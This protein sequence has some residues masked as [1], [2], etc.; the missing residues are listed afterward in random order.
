MA[1][2]GAFFGIIAQ[3][4]LNTVSNSG[5]LVTGGS[6]GVSAGALAYVVRQIASGKLVHR[7]VARAEEENRA[8]ARSAQEQNRVYAGFIEKRLSGSAYD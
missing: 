4:D 7:D 2:F 8:L 3:A 5:L 1:A 6:A